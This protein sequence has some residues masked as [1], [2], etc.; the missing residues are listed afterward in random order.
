MIEL[1]MINRT[2]EQDEVVEEVHYSFQ[3]HPPEKAAWKEH[4]IGSGKWLIFP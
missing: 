3:P 4:A 2:A 1:Y